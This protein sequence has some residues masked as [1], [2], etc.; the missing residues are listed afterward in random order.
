MG[1]IQ[2]AWDGL[3]SPKASPQGSPKME[4]SQPPRPHWTDN[5]TVAYER[6]VTEYAGTRYVDVRSQEDSP[7]VEVQGPARRAEE[8]YSEPSLRTAEK[9]SPYRRRPGVEYLEPRYVEGR[10]V[11]YDPRYDLYQADRRSA[12]VERRVVEPHEM[13]I[14]GE[15]VLSQ[16]TS[17]FATSPMQ[18]LSVPTSRTDYRAVDRERIPT[19]QRVRQSPTSGQPRS[20]SPM[21]V[22]EHDHTMYPRE[23]Q[24]SPLQQAVQRSLPQQVVR[25]A[26]P[27][28]PQVI[29]R[30]VEVPV[31]RVVE[32]IVEVPKIVEKVVTVEVP[33]EKASC[34][35]ICF[36]L[37]QICF[38]LPRSCHI[39]M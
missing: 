39:P 17:E 20:S 19:P 23:V 24:M 7:Y 10:Q 11:D 14:L 25:A 33:V 27:T 1:S 34:V 32:K 22:R 8:Y 35:Q 30:V 12:P 16:T 15:N 38:A 18:G 21:V 2:R 37:V 36:A 31:D 26:P 3:W 29:E 9:T 13:R 5:P 6:P 4:S 28:P